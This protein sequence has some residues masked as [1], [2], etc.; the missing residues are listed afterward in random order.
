MNYRLDMRSIG[1]GL[2]IAGALIAFTLPVYAQSDTANT[3]AQTEVKLEPSVDPA[4]PEKTTPTAKSDLST[5][6]ATVEAFIA[7]LDS[8]SR[9][10]HEN[11]KKDPALLRE[12]CRVLLNE[13]LDINAMAQAT[14]AEIWELMTAPQ[15]DTIRAA[16]EHRM[17]S[18]CVRQFAQYEGENMRLAGIKQTSGGMLATIRLGTRDDAKMVTW[19]LQ[20]SGPHSVRAVDVI[21]EGRSIVSDARNE[22]AAVLQS[23][24]GDIEALIA[25]MQK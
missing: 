18:N 12:G 2:R 3:P 22:F 10:I 24:N 9:A 14:N 19:R 7:R 21:T 25:F 1:A 16:F 4:P 6:T 5:Q 13:V 23:V 20:N 8:A 11:A 17:V 15:R